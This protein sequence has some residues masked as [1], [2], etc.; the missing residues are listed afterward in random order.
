[1]LTAAGILWASA[2]AVAA[3]GAS[4]LPGGQCG[5]VYMIVG[6]G[7][8]EPPGE[9]HTAELVNDIKRHTRQ[10]IDDVAVDYPATAKNLADYANSSGKGT[11]AVRGMLTDEVGR[12]PTQKIVMLGY[13]QGA[14]II[15]DAIAGGAGGKLGPQT[16][17]VPRNIS[18]HVTAVIQFGD[19]RHMA[20]L[21]FDVGTS[22]HNGRFPRA[23]DQ[24]LMPFS[25]VI[26]SYC[27]A[28]DLF[29]DSGNSLP[30]H[31]SYLRKYRDDATRFVVNAIGR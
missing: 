22:T 25:R 3:G 10:R 20:G 11:A 26:Q 13:S 14:H 5:S 15:G 28:D 23:A 30:V 6:R 24:S 27:D 21:P 8:N 31:R 19:P 29:C 18:E 12:C 17:P 16:P 9:G 1:M 4:A 7:T 2:S